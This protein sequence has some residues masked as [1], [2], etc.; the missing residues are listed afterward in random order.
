VVLSQRERRIWI[1]AGE[2]R[3]SRCSNGLRV[4]TTNW[5]KLARRPQTLCD[6]GEAPNCWKCVPTYIH[7]VPSVH[8]ADVWMMR[9]FAGILQAV[10]NPDEAR[11]MQAEADAMAKSGD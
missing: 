8:A 3:R 9:E 10:G 7:K 2:D 1:S 6:Y 11:R 4:L 5:K